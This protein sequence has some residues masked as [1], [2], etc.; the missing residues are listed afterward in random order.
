MGKIDGRFVIILNPERVLSESELAASG[1]LGGKPT[2]S[3]TFRIGAT[4]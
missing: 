3:A 4:P 2:A 1:E